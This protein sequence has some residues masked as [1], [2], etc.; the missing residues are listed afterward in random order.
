LL[1]PKDALPEKNP[2]SNLYRYKQKRPP[3]KRPLC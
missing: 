2:V 3:V 1:R